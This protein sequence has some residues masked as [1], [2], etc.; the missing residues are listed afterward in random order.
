MKT[1]FFIGMTGLMTVIPVLCFGA[2]FI[3]AQCAQED[4][5]CTSYTEYTGGKTNCSSYDNIVYVGCK[6]VYTCNTCKTNYQKTAKTVS[7]G[8]CQ[9]TYNTCEY[10][11]TNVSCNLTPNDCA[12]QDSD[13]YAAGTGYLARNRYVLDL[14]S[15]EC[16][17]QADYICDTE[18]HYYG[19]ANCTWSSGTRVCNGCTYCK[20][21][22]TL[23]LQSGRIL[24]KKLDACFSAKESIV[25]EST[26][27]GNYYTRVIQRARKEKYQIIFVYVFLMSIEQNLARIKQCVALG[28]H[29]V[30]TTDV[31]RRYKR[32]LQNF[33]E[34]I[35]MVHQWNLYYNGEDSFEIIA[36]G[37]GE[38]LEIMDDAVYNQFKKEAK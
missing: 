19:T 32:S 3:A 24:L 33:F 26:V 25:L 18:N 5:T 20:G 1:T 15:C 22:D 21:G 34:I 29:N 23:G 31:K 16:K 10:S 4:T 38:Q 35:P 11:G 27:S 30:P 14:T 37:A 13:W 36:R 7:L 12:A 9:A 2:D 6:R 17:Q 28:G 8:D